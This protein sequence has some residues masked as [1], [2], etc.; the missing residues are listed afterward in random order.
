MEESGAIF[1]KPTWI[2]ATFGRLLVALLRRG[3]GPAHM[4]VLEVRGRKSGSVYSL[5]V[6]PL[7]YDGKLYL[8]APRGRTQWVRNVEASREIALRRGRAVERYAVRALSDIEKL[9][10][11]KAYLDN[12]KG[13]VQR[14]FPVAAGSP[15]EAFEPLSSRYPAFEI[16]TVI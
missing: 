13:E 11:L 4:R 5:P 6:D 12:F 16:S 2:E 9:P 3:I 7:R 14:F 8:V 15:T 1:A 10:V